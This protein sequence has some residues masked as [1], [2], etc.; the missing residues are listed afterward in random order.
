LSELEVG[1]NAKSKENEEIGTDAKK[2]AKELERYKS[3]NFYNLKVF[4][5]MLNQSEVP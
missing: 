3:S 2:T 4:F 1:I 5:N